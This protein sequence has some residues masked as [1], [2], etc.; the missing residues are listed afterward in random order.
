MGIAPQRLLSGEAFLEI[1]PNFDS[2]SML[3]IQM[4]LEEEFGFELDFS[5]DQSNL[6]MNV[7]ELAQAVVDQKTRDSSTGRGE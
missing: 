5:R 4:L 3:E 1:D 6:P 2:L 7:H